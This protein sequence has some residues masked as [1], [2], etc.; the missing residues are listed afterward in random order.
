MKKATK[1]KLENSLKATKRFFYKNQRIIIYVCIALVGA[2][3]II[4]SLPADQ[5]LENILC[6]VGTGAF[7]SLMLEMIK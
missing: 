2:I 4:L 5:D 3:S 6:G 7:T 1:R